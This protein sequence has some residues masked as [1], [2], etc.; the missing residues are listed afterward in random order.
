MHKGVEKQKLDFVRSSILKESKL[1]SLIV[2]DL[3]NTLWTPELYQIRNLSGSEPIANRDV[4]LFGD[5]FSILQELS[6][7]TKWESTLLAVASRT[8]KPH[9]ARALL[10][11]FRIGEG[12]GVSLHDLFNYKEIYPGAKTAHFASLHNQT[13]I[14]YE[15]MLFFDDARDGKFGN[16]D[17]VAKLGVM[18]V[19]VP[20]GIT[21]VAWENAI[22]S[23]ATAKSS[24]MRM[25]CIIDPPQSAKYSNHRED[26]DLKATIKLW[27]E[28]KSFGFCRL[29]NGE[30][31]FFHRSSVVSGPETALSQGKV[32][33]VRV[34]EGRDGRPACTSVR[35]W[36]ENDAGTNSFRS[37][38]T[39]RFPCFSMNQPF[40]ALVAQ[41]FKTLETRNSNILK[42]LAGKRV[43][44]HVGQRTYPDGGMHR[45]IMRQAQHACTGQR[46]SE[47]DI[48]RLTNLPGGYSRGY[49]VAILELGETDLI[50]DAQERSNPDI[51][52]RAVATGAAM[53]KYLTTVKFA[54]WLLAP[55]LPLRG[56][57]GV[58]DV[59]IP[60]SLLPEQLQNCN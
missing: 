25:G 10:H 14:P 2:F 37:V 19:Y 54:T 33:F 45:V 47:E 31:V 53:G 3:D 17:A 26:C 28:E 56:K 24:G 43:A 1:P 57:P 13:G 40:A 29:E 39:V 46:L 5:V 6:T 51:E 11:Q 34:G 48:N 16:C 36:S 58:F 23:F 50:N 7:A 22:R 59:E 4:Q 12:P 21:Y 8:N 9:W 55:G 20:N 15:D 41:G 30:E 49:V 32:V 35:V 60:I 42:Q 44:L 38:S 27:K 52:L 18:S